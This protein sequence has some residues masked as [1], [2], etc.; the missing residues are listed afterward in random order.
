MAFSLAECR[1]SA[2]IRQPDDEARAG[3]RAGLVPAAVLGADGAVMGI[4]DLLGDAQA[5]P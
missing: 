5:Q 4:H 3:D 1:D 2:S